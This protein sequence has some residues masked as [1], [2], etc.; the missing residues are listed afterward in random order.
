MHH[1]VIERGLNATVHSRLHQ[2]RFGRMFRT[3]QPATFKEADLR[4]LA[5]AMTSEPEIDPKTKKPMVTSEKKIDDEENF[6]IP[7]GYTYFGQFV[8]HD[9]T[10]DPMSSLMKMNDPSGLVDFR[11]PAL[12][13]DNVYGRGPDDQPYMYD[14]DGKK[15]LLGDRNLTAN[16][17]HKILTKDLPRFRQ[18]ALISDKRNDENVIVSQLQGLF[19]R[20]HNFVVDQNPDASFADVQQ[21]VRWHYQ[22]LIL[23]DYLPRLVGRELVEEILPHINT[24]SGKSIFKVE[25][26][27]LFFKWENF[28]FM[29]VEFSGAVY[30]FGHSMIRPVYRLSLGD[31]PAI[32]PEILHLEGRRMI[33]APKLDDGLNGFR[34]F[35]EQWGIDWKLFFETRDHKLSPLPSFRNKKRVQPAYK[36]DTSL[37]SPLA[38]LP[39]FSIPGTNDPVDKKQPNMLA[40]RNLLRGMVLGLPSGQD[41]ARYMGID[42]IPDHDLIA[43]KANIDGLDNENHK[44]IRACGESF[45]NKA[46]LWFYILAE[47]RHEWVKNRKSEA[48][49]KEN[50]TPTRL[51]PVGGRIVAEVLIGLI[52]GDPNSFLSLNP[53]WKPDFGDAT[54]TSVFDHFTMGDLIELPIP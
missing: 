16:D 20:F 11:T 3:L 35:P 18:R 48:E 21:I 17:P 49:E 7:A 45:R 28:P 1:G 33:F 40:L 9:I 30:R 47:A 27:L 14:A 2:G 12:D 4:K 8:D 37:V 36:I 54:A 15:F 53:N 31:L 38:A 26:N 32:E 29:P 22:W 41:V 44:T 10:F 23:F 43:G 52:Y 46:P 6:G 50:P 5:V 24:E 51:G 39:E 13:L 34:E 42:P 19:L 25:A